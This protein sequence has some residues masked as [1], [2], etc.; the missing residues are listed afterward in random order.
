MVAREDCAMA[1]QEELLIHNVYF[2]LVDRS[3]AARQQ[4]VEACRRWLPGHPGIVFFACGERCAALVRDVNDRDW[5]VGLHIVFKDKAA[6]DFYQDTE[7]HHSFIAENR[8][9]WAR[10]RVFD[11]QAGQSPTP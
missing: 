7:A 9:N 2:T 11:S 5:D 10:V 3:P 1:G 4:L 6:H 8:G